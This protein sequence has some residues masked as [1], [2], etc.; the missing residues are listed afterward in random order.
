MIMVALRSDEE[1]GSKKADTLVGLRK[2]YGNRYDYGL[3][4][5]A[6]Q[7]SLGVKWRDQDYWLTTNNEHLSIHRVG[8]FAVD[9]IDPNRIYPLTIYTK[10]RELFKYMVNASRQWSVVKG[11]YVQQRI[12]RAGST[13]T[14]ADS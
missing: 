13:E 1:D 2:E 5:P 10:E 12:T 3:V 7:Q 11:R 6:F 14:R 4:I 9:N 8:L